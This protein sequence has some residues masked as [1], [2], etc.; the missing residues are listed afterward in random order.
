M[1]LGCFFSQWR[2]SRIC[3][4]TP[5][6]SIIVRS[7][8]VCFCSLLLFIYFFFLTFFVC[9]AGCFLQNASHWKPP[10]PSWMCKPWP[11][12]KTSVLEPG[13]AVGEGGPRCQRRFHTWTF[14]SLSPSAVLW[15]RRSFGPLADNRRSIPPYP[16]PQ[17]QPTQACI[18]NGSC[19]LEFDHWDVTLSCLV[20]SCLLR[21]SSSSVWK[22]P[23]GGFRPRLSRTRKYEQTTAR[24]PY[25]GRWRTWR[26][27]I[28][29]SW[30]SCISSIFPVF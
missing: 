22:T 15:R 21:S 27:D 26:N 7:F 30:N 2:F 24:W 10:I 8:F 17:P 6:L 5:D 23:C 4:F 14:G 16:P 20:L 11:A 18:L 28:N 1:F 3:L 29:K 25:V 13:C 9:L 12:M 19:D